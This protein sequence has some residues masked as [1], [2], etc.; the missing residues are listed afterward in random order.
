MSTMVASICAVLLCLFSHVL[1]G[2][3]GQPEQVHL[4]Y[5]EDATTM[6]VTW[7]TKDPTNTSIVEYGTNDMNMIAKGVADLFTD[8]GPE[9]RIFYT[10][11]VKVMNLTPGQKYMYH[12]G[13]HLGWSDIFTFTAMPPGS[14]WSPRFAVY[15]DM[16]NINAQSMGRLQEETQRGHFDA[17]LHVGD[18]AYNMDTDNARFG[19]EFM[20]QVEAV[21]AYIP[22]MTCVGN[23]E[24]AY[25]FSNYRERF[26]MPAAGGDGQN[27]WWSFNI[28]PAHIIAFSTEVYFYTSYGTAQIMN[29]FSWIEQDLIEANKPENR[30]ARPWIITMGH[31]PAYCSNTDGDDCTKHQSIVRTGG[32]KS[33]SL[34]TLFYKAGVDL[35]FWAHE[36]SYEREWPVYNF[37]VCNG[38]LDAPYTNPPAPVHIVTGSAGCQERHDP[39]IAD[40]PDWSAIRLDDYGYTRMTIHNRTHLYMEQ[41]SDDQDGKIVDKV[42][43]IKDKHGPGTYNCM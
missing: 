3:Y 37:K 28:G 18:M 17:I 39:F 10:H 23:H 35:Q 43:L 27:L 15:G 1:G 5:G 22:Y 31:R 7:V 19:D 42:M 32:G 24:S 4:S 29:Q 21:A 40:K 12:C 2:F 13:S 34:E 41:V 25:N 30:Q 16:G 20:R 6:V 33:P 36:H 38:S 8:G 9:K 26:T 11:R 14:D